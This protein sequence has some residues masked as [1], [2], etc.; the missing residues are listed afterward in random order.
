MVLRPSI[1]PVIDTICVPAKKA[2][3]GPLR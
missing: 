1:E 3:R 2:E